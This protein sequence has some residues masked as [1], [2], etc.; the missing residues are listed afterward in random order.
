[1][2]SRRGTTGFSTQIFD[3]VELAFILCSFQKMRNLKI[4]L[5][6][7]CVI[8]AALLVGCDAKGKPVTQAEFGTTWPLTVSEGRLACTRWTGGLMAVTFIAP[9]GKE[10]ALNGIAR[11]SGYFEKIE[12]IQTPVPNNP[13]A[14]KDIGVLIDKGLQL[15]PQV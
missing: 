8:A 11:Q 12:Q 9:D 5:S 10:S 14:K 3:K 1:L 2:S 6:I 7:V 15:C 4:Q 13:P